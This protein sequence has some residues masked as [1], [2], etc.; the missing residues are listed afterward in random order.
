MKTNKEYLIEMLLKE[1]GLS[2]VDV[3]EEIF[4][5]IN[6]YDWAVFCS[7]MGDYDHPGERIAA[8]EELDEKLSHYPERTWKKVWELLKG[9]GEIS[10]FYHNN[11]HKLEEEYKEK[12]T[13]E[14]C[15][16]CDNRCDYCKFACNCYTEIE[17]G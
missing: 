15:K 3:V 1:T 10:D 14:A 17:I 4:N 12:K 13:V 6:E 11:F 7:Q 2:C 8:K 9:D 5:I 16:I